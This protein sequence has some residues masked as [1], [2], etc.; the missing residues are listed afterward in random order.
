[1]VKTS[2]NTKISIWS[3]LGRRENPTF[4]LLL[5]TLDLALTITAYVSCSEK[6]C[7]DLTIHE[8]LMW[9]MLLLKIFV[10]MSGMEC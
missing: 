5:P 10:T 7:A 9:L 2:R 8:L 3:N 4:P 1:M 6:L